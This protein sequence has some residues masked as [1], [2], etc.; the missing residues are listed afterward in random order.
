MGKQKHFLIGFVN[1]A[2]IYNFNSRIINVKIPQWDFLVGYLVNKLNTSKYT[3]E[4]RM[5]QM[6]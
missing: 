3:R 6:K 2:T 5:A 4:V 1:S